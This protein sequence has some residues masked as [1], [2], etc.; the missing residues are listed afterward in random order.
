MPQKPPD[1]SSRFSFVDVQMHKAISIVT[2]ATII[3]IGIQSKKGRLIQLME[4]RKHLGVFHSRAANV[5]ADLP[6]S[7]VALPQ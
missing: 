6:T 4:Q 5:S 3:K 2:Q 7:D 1:I